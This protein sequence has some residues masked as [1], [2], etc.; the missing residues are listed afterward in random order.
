ME[1]RCVPESCCG[2]IIGLSA[3]AI[4]AAIDEAAVGQFGE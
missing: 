3:L 2:R 1:W 4:G